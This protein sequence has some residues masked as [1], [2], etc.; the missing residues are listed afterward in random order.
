[1]GKKMLAPKTINPGDKVALLSPAWAAPAYFPE[2]HAQAV[3]R[4]ERLLDVEVIEYPTTRKMNA[5]L[6]ERAADVNAAFADPSIRAILTSVGGDDQ[7]RLTRLLDPA[8]PQADPKP[9]FGYSDNTNILNWLWINGVSAYHGGATQVHFGPGPLVDA[10]HLVTLRAA[11]FGW[12]DTLMPTTT[13]SQDFGFDWSMP[14]A[15]T[16]DSPRGPALPVEFL[17][18]D[19]AVTGHT[20]GGCL[21][22]LDQLAIADRLPPAAD[23][24]GAIL[25]LETSELIPPAD[26]VG[27]WI[28]AF[29]ERGYLDAAAGLIF[30]RPVVDDRDAPA[31]AEALRSRHD[32]YTEYL[33][34]NLSLYRRDLPVCLNLPFGHTRPQLILPYGG[35]VTLDPV[36]ETVTAHFPHA[37]RYTPTTPQTRPAPNTHLAKDTHLA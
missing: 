30:A 13:D 14:E 34:A 23:L 12:G 33:L 32:S 29:G 27:R 6:E 22:V 31:P 20:W 28:R 1:M 25:I 9:F 8:L 37:E 36:A 35:E 18:S 24:E 5:S 16:E 3:E 7:I 2:I 21:E 26:T 19:D 11:L 17:G 10:E 4:L 15:L